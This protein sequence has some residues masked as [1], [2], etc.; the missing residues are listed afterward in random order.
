[1]EQDLNAE[2]KMLEI[3]RYRNRLR[4]EYSASL[5]HSEPEAQRR[6]EIAINGYALRQYQEHWKRVESRGV[7]ISDG[8]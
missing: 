6:I 4:T 2:N 8:R 7:R 1:M 5:Q 3:D